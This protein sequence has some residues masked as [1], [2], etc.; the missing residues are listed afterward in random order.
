MA[1]AV[2][3]GKIRSASPSSVQHSNKPFPIRKKFN[4][5]WKEVQ[6][7]FGA[8][9][10]ERI[11]SAGK[12]YVRLFAVYQKPKVLNKLD[13][14][15]LRLLFRAASLAVFYTAEAQYARDAQLDFV[16]MENRHYAGRPD[17]VHM[18]QDLVKSRQF[19]SARK[20]YLAHSSDDLTPFPAYRDEAGKIGE[21]TATML[22]VDVR[23]KELVRRVVNLKQPAQVVMLTD[24]NCHFCLALSRTL[25]GYPRTNKALEEHTIRVTLPGSE[26]EFESLL[27]WDKTHPEQPVGIMYSLRGWPKIKIMGTPQILFLWHGRITKTL[28]G[29]QGKQDVATIKA[30]LRTIGLLPDHRADSNN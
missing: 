26:L 27:K 13:D 10:K 19:S 4:Q 29:W 5:Y 6:S 18:Y 11:H 14:Y 21:N 22:F 17:V 1:I 28:T 24:P 23:E 9:W 20:F 16:E 8:G 2:T 15:D 7:S 3:D 12:P 30:G 25:Q